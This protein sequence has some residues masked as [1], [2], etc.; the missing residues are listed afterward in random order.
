METSMRDKREG[1]RSIL[2]IP[3]R[4]FSTVGV[5]WAF[6]VEG[7]VANGPGL[8]HRGRNK[9]GFNCSSS[10]IPS[11]AMSLWIKAMTWSGRPST[12]A[13]KAAIRISCSIQ[14]EPESAVVRR[15]GRSCRAGA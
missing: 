1:L 9:M 3:Q 10:R 11:R 12:W 15:G 6:Q 4:A 13:M 2:S 14:T 5:C 7:L 8:H